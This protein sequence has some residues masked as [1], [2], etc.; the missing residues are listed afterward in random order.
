MVQRSTGPQRV[1]R[2]QG[3][4][5]GA[6]PDGRRAMHGAEAFVV[7]PQRALEQHE[8]TGVRAL[9]RAVGDPGSRANSVRSALCSSSHSVPGPPVGAEHPER[10]AIDVASP[11][12]WRARRACSEDPRSG[13]PRARGG[14][15]SATPRRRGAPRGRRLPA[16]RRAG[17]ARAARGSRSTARYRRAAARVE[18]GRY[19]RIEGASPAADLH[20]GFEYLG[21]VRDRGHA[22]PTR[23]P[24]EGHQTSRRA[25]R[26]PVERWHHV[27]A[28]MTMT[29]ASRRTPV[30]S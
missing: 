16:E 14:S 21:Q 30:P 13:S 12:T 15:R 19:S 3:A 4:P 11:D 25:C 20:A 8:L 9:E 7:L 24:R 29:D 17:H 18:V 23:C 26:A 2:D 22:A 5:P 27:E 1:E 6:R 10:N 28:V